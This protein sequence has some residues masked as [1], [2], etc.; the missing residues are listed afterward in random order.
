M[1]FLIGISCVIWTHSELK[2]P[3][4]RLAVNGSVPD[5]LKCIVSIDN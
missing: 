4:Y 5:I 1:S 3:V 2:R